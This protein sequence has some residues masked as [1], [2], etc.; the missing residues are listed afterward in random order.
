MGAEQLLTAVAMQLLIKKKRVYFL[1]DNLCNSAILSKDGHYKPTGIIFIQ[2][3]MLEVF[4]MFYNRLFY[5]WLMVIGC[6]SAMSFAASTSGSVHNSLKCADQAIRETR[7]FDAIVSLDIA[8]TQA[9]LKSPD[10]AVA[11][12]LKGHAYTG[13]AQ[14]HASVRLALAAK[15]CYYFSPTEESF[16]KKL[17]ILSPHLALHE[18][19]KRYAHKRAGSTHEERE[20][21]NE[22]WQEVHKKL[23]DAQETASKKALDCFDHSWRTVYLTLAFD[24]F[25]KKAMSVVDQITKDREKAQEM[26]EAQKGEDSFDASFLY[27]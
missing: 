3:Y 25:N 22:D 4:D 1:I 16:E 7:Y 9:Q 14:A 27:I 8:L 21:D 6:H 19:C 5:S 13:L 12:N 23:M 20:F 15:G 24:P 18:L 2:W 10:K 26:A 11:L 17:A